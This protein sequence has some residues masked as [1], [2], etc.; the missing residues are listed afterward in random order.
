MAT[1][2]TKTNGFNKEKVQS[3]KRQWEAAEKAAEKEIEKV[4]EALGE[5][6]DG[7]LERMET[8]GIQRGVFKTMVAEGK[9]RQ[10][11]DNMREKYAENPDVQD[12]YDNVRLAA[13]MLLFDDGE[14]PVMRKPKP[15]GKKPAAKGG[16]KV[17]TAEEAG[18]DKV[19]SAAG[20]STP[21]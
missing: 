6:K 3:A 18:D 19:A 4:K 12:Q 10:K 1:D 2:A 20:S 9:L 11:A 14:L 5:K 7:I 8:I 13:G 17:K 15:S 21:Q 16:A